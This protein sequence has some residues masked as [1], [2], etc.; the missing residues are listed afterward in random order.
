VRGR[1]VEEQPV[2]AV[3]IENVIETAAGPEPR[4]KEGIRFIRWNR[5]QAGR[6]SRTGW[7]GSGCR[8]WVRGRRKSICGR[9]ASGRVVWF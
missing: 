9:I 6:R 1:F 4:L 2:A 7:S 5:Q 8:I 3:A